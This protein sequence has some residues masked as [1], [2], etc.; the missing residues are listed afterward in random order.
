MAKKA[1]RKQFTDLAVEQLRP[2]RSGRVEIRDALMPGLV[3][4]V[5]ER[6]VKSWSVIYKVPGERGVSPTGRP[7]RGSQHR[8]TLGQWPALKV[9]R[10]R[11]EA[12]DL[13][14]VVLEG[15]DPRR[16][17]QAEN[18]LRHTNS[19]KAVSERLVKQAKK[20]IDGWRKIEQTLEAHVWPEWGPRP[21]GDLAQADVHALLDKLVADGR[22]GIA[23]EVRKHLSRLFNFA[24]ARALI[25]ASP[26]AG[27]RRRDLTQAVKERSLSDAEVRALWVAT[28]E[29]GY[30][31]GPAVRLLLLTGQRKS[32]WLRARWSEIDSDERL[33]VLPRERFKSRRGHVVPLEGEAW[34]IVE[35]LPRWRK[36]DALFSTSGGVTPVSGDS[37]AKARLDRLVLAELRKAAGDP[38]S[39]M[40]PFTLHDLRRTCETR[41]ARLSVGR[42]VRDAVLG[43]ARDGLQRTYNKHDYLKEKREAL[44]AYGAHVMEVVV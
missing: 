5:T 36:G 28:G 37:K 27:M 16:D 30:A 6:G 20:E 32:E 38:K 12:R 7:L 9:V 15:R 17:R 44:A 39:T 26:M 3:L 34:R 14:Q 43:H 24:A 22:T 23:R 29:M 31:Y 33:L 1:L 41:M 42:E 35:G 8:V 18:L 10:A 19:V 25:P 40:E 11:D 13:M 4:R 2:P 21:I